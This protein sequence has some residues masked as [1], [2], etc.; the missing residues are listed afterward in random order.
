MHATKQEVM[1]AF[2]LPQSG[3]CEGGKENLV[4]EREREKWEKIQLM[5]KGKATL[6][7]IA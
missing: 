3:V 2:S 6:Y 4:E 5:A 7:S 1:S